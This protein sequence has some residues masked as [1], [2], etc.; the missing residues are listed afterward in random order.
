MNLDDAFKLALALLNLAGGWFLK[1]LW[2]SFRE[3]Q[4]ADKELADKVQ[5][6]EVLVAGQ[7]VQRDEFRELSAALFR[8]LDLISEKID[9]KQDKS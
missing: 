2:S 9:K 7:Y 6:I 4:I 5:K 8:K 3:L 1:V